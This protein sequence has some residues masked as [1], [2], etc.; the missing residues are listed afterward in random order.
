MADLAIAC[1]DVWKSYRIYHQRSHTLKE[2]VLSRRNM[3]EDFWA[4]KGVEIEVEEGSTFGVIGPNGSGKSTLLRIA[5]GAEEADVGSV[6]RRRG[7]RT[8]MLAQH[9]IG[10]VR[11][12]LETVRAARTD[13]LAV[14]GWGDLDR[15]RVELAARPHLARRTAEFLGRM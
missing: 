15:L 3:Y 9:P 7:L 4:L 11:T 14:D 13:L 10:D 12:P 5:V 8:A 2:K 6:T 1:R